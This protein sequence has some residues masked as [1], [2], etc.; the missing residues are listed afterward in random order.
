MDYKNTDH[1][2]QRRRMKAALGKPTVDQASWYFLTHFFV[3]GKRSCVSEKIGRSLLNTFLRRKK[4]EVPT[5]SPLPHSFWSQ[6]SSVFSRHLWTRRF[7][8][9]FA[10]S[11]EDLFYCI[12][13]VSAPKNIIAPRNIEKSTD[14]PTLL[15]QRREWAS[16]VPPCVYACYV[17]GS[18]SSQSATGS[19]S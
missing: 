6:K 13:G 14:S 9:F 10:V 5:F 2:A 8:I 7:S 12:W 16:S 19:N 18:A 4:I 1:S 3:S 15:E 11:Y 17:F